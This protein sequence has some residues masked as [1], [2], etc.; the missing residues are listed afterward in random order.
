MVRVLLLFLMCSKFS[1]LHRAGVAAP[2]LHL[3]VVKDGKMIQVR[4][5]YFLEAHLAPNYCEASQTFGAV[6]SAILNLLFE[7][8]LVTGVKHFATKLIEQVLSVIHTIFLCRSS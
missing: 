3:D 4:V 7:I 6:I 5:L 1:I 8:L 2:G